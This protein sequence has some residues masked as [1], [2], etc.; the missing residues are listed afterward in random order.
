MEPETYT[1][2]AWTETL[3]VWNGEPFAADLG[4]LPKFVSVEKPFALVWSR[5]D[6]K[7]AAKRYAATMDNNPKVF[8]LTTEYPLEMARTLILK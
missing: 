8:L 5:G 7:E 6:E 1:V 3:R 4:R 2:I